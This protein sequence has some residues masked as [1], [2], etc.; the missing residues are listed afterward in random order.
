MVKVAAPP[1]VLPVM[2]TTVEVTAGT[3]PPPSGRNA[4][5]LFSRMALPRPVVVML[6]GTLPMPGTKFGS[7]SRPHVHPA[8]K[9]SGTTLSLPAV[10]IGFR[11]VNDLSVA[12]RA[13]NLP[14]KLMTGSVMQVTVKLVRTA[15]VA[16][17]ST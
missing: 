2:E 15:I 8:E 12:K 10:Y 14:P 5:G 4:T 1:V 11:L 6:V 16:L 7:P 13:S 17:S 9:S 3:A